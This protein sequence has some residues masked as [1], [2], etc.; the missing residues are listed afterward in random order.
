[1]LTLSVPT[2]PVSHLSRATVWMPDSLL[3]CWRALRWQQMSLSVEDLFNCELVLVSVSKKRYFRASPLQKDSILP[4][5]S[6]ARP[7][8]S[9]TMPQ[10]TQQL[11]MMTSEALEQ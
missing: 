10:C 5:C 7:A 11:S 4:L 6:G 2:Q 1:V 9:A 8:T 3:S